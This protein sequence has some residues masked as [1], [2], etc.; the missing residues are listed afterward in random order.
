MDNGDD[1]AEPSEDPTQNRGKGAFYKGIE[2]KIAVK[3][4]RANVSFL[5]FHFLLAFSE[6]I[7]MFVVNQWDTYT[8]KWDAVHLILAPLSEEEIA[9]RRE[10]IADVTDPLA[11]FSRTD[12]DAEGEVDDTE[13][14]NASDLPP[15]A[16][17]ATT[18]VASASASD[19]NIVDVNG[20]G[21]D[22][23]GES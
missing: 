6:L 22:V 12:A 23:N 5:S 3:K 2:R 4:K 19:P 17:A 7:F 10:A 13:M 11:M 16:A 18:V 9:E 21:V 20:S 14:H 1:N 15:A 8:D